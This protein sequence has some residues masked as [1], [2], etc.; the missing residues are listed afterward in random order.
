MISAKQSGI[1]MIEAAHGVEGVGCADGAGHHPRSGSNSVGI[2]VAETDANAE[3]GRVGDGLLSVG[4]FR[5]YGHHAD[6]AFRC[7]PHAIEE[8]D[9]WSE[10]LAFGMGASFMRREEWAFEMDPDGTSAVERQLH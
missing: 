9:G 7:L 2:A 1:A 5:R 10:E 4:Q 8:R 6:V 3:L